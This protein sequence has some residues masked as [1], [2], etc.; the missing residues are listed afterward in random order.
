MSKKIIYTLVV[1]AL[2]FFITSLIIFLSYKAD[3]GKDSEDII[4]EKSE[5]IIKE[6]VFIRVKVFFLT[7]R[8]RYMRP[9]K[10]EIERPEIKEELYKK[11]ID[12][13]IRGE[14][15]YIAPIP[16]GLRLRSLF[17]VEKQKLVI[18]DFSEELI[19]KFPSGTAAE[20]E[21][22][23]FVVNNICYNFKEIKKVKI[24]VSGNEYRTISGH[25]DLENPFYPN[26][27]Y[28]RDN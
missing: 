20:L 13:M 22:I 9:V 7:E 24:M 10:Y 8:S 2:I 15:N 26:F 6:Q 16:E 27:R 14:E 18:L 23:Y 4:D 25:I 17:Y 1:V 5:E 28:I 11:L 12:L 19:T 21:F 3:S